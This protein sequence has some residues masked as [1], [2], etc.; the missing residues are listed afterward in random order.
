MTSTHVEA[1]SVP[2]CFIRIDGVYSALRT[3]EKRVADYIRAHPEELIHFTVTEL[4]DATQ[5]SESTVVRLCQKLGYKGYQEFKIMLARDLVSPADTI[6][7]AIAPSDPIDVLK[8]KVF[9]AN[10][11][12]LRDTIEVLDDAMLAR[13]AAAIRSAGKMDIYGIGGSSSIAFDAYHKFHRIGIACIAHSDT[14]M[15]ATSAVLLAPGDVALGISHTGS[16]HDIVEAIRLAK[17]AGATTICITHNATSPI[18]RVSDIALFTAARET[19]FSSDAMTSRLAQLSI[20]DTV[21]LAVALAD[22]D[23]SLALIQKTRRAS[24]AKRY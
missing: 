3:A 4:A 8:T 6:F 17:E 5:T 20:I 1:V 13:A 11:Q 10:I 14:D 16:S 19:A 18:T 22:Y 2:G 15:M 9:Q 7:E 21:Y 23:K 12:A 24:A